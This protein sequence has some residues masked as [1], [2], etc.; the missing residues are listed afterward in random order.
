MLP[1][2][3]VLALILFIAR[4]WIAIP[5]WFFCIIIGFAVLK[6]IIMFPFVWRAYD[7]DR[8]GISRS[9]IGV[10]GITI[11]RLAPAGYIDVQGELWKAER[12]GPGPQIEKGDMVRVIKMKGLK[13]FV[14]PDASEDRNQ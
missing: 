1:E 13:L 14:E 6:D 12:I 8:P 3:A 5:A 4:Q 7:W 10:R 9:M 11:E 2:T